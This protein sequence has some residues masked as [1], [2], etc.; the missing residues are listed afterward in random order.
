MAGS[1]TPISSSRSDPADPVSGSARDGR[2]R[3]PGRAVPVASPGLQGALSI[4]AHFG[5]MMLS[6]GD[7]AF[8]VRRAMMVTAH[9]L[10]IDAL[11]VDLKFSSIIAV[12][13]RDQEQR[14]IVRGIAPPGINAWRIGALEQMARRVPGDA[15]AIATRLAQIEAA[16]PHYS[17]RSVALG[18]GGACGAFA[19]LNGGGVLEIA[20]A[21]C[22]GG[23]G[24]WLRLELSRRQL[25]Q[26]AVAAMCAL[27]ASGIYCVLAG[28]G[29]LLGFAFMRHTSGFISSVLFLV[30]GFPLVTALLE[31]VQYETQ[32]AMARF[33][34]AIMVILA[35]SF[36]L[37]IT[38]ALA[39]F[40]LAPH[41][42]LEL[43]LAVKLI[44]RGV[45]SFAGAAGFA[46]LYNSSPRAVPVIGFLA[47]V[48]NVLRLDL[49]DEGMALAP[50]AFLGAVVVGLA[51]SLL[52]MR[53]NEPRLTLAVPGIIIMMPGSYALQTFIL[54]HDGRTLEALAA[55]V[56]AAF[57][58]GG[59][60]A[61]LA[62]ARVLSGRDRFDR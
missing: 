38:A 12:A 14:A 52:Q 54:F 5:L 56:L 16:R 50:A 13:D 47:L 3:S 18:V 30:P 23:I 21:A 57:V 46:M 58:V 35:M 34:H 7:A 42:P 8:R 29:S 43:T 27:V 41:Q 2:I 49:V 20:A 55:G 62:V 31:F 25:N 53:V 6:A 17:V 19:F 45:A 48:G 11:S 9:A 22:G 60:G 15:D 28:T 4:V 39:G 37:A 33:A 10:K 61:G 24:Q 40:E 32:P 59:L 36:G 1:S 26:Y 44:L 51:A